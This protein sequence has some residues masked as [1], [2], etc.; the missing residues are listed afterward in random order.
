MNMANLHS[1]LVASPD[2][3]FTVPF[4][5]DD[6][7][8]GRE[9]ILYQIEECLQ[10]QR[11]VSLAGIGGVGYDPFSLFFFKFKLLLSHTFKRKRL[12]ILLA[13]LKLPSN[14]HIDSVRYIHKAIS[15][16]CLL[17]T[18]KDSTRHIKKLAINSIFQV[19]TI[20]KPTN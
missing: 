18:M 9:N 4:P 6:K 20:H 10:T 15:S 14:S 17:P 19:E 1:A 16:G 13:N 11:R 2:P 3:A 7:F 12:M 5:H 8:I